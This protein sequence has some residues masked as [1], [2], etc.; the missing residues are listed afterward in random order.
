MSSFFSAG[1]RVF[2]H[3]SMNRFLGVRSTEWSIDNTNVNLMG[4]ECA[5]SMP[6]A[7]PRAMKSQRYDTTSWTYYN[8]EKF[9]PGD[10][11]VK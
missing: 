10:I 1:R 4:N 8:G 9:V 3:S 11:T 5:P 6:P 2:K 7:D